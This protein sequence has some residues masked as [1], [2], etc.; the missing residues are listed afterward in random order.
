MRRLLLLLLFAASAQAELPALVPRE[1]LFG[2]P[3]RLDPQIS[4]DGSKL[5]WLAPDKNGVLN[6]W[7]STIEGADPHPVTNEPGY[8]IHYYG[9][10]ADGKR[11]LYLHD[12]SLIHISEPTRLLS[13]SYAV[14]CL[15]KK[16]KH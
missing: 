16:K 3:Q 10:A 9:W 15:K 14:F 1:V 2:N 13:I 7:V 6:V 5:S 12:L 11:I 4:P 8:P